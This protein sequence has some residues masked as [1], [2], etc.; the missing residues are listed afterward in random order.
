MVTE[1]QRLAPGT[2]KESHTEYPISS[3]FLSLVFSMDQFPPTPYLGKGEMDTYLVV[4][5][6][7]F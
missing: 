4:V 2:S 7:E 6:F 3:V 5:S 1:V